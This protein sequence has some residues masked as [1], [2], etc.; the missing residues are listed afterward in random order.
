MSKK[1]QVLQFY[2]SLRFKKYLFIIP[3][4]L[5][6]LAGSVVF[7][8]TFV[9][10]QVAGTGLEVSPPSQEVTVDPGGTTTIKA[11][12]TNKSNET[13]PIA[14]RIED[15][16]AKGDEGQIELT[17]NSEYSVVSWTNLSTTNFTLSPG[18]AREVTATITAPSDAAG[19][20][21]GS[22]VFAVKP[23][24]PEPG[25]A[26]ISQQIASL[27]LVKVAGPV[28]EKIELKSFSAP[29][30]SEFGP[31]TF[32]LAFTNTGNIHT[33]PYGLINVTD[34]FGRKVADIVVPGN[35]IFPQADRVI[36]AQLDQQFLIGPYKATALMYYGAENENL[37]AQT[38]FFV[39]P[40]RI[41]GVI[42]A[43]LVVLFLL[44]KRLKKAGKALFG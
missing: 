43:V 42:L 44:R 32:D 37:T 15:F 17:A 9:T 31:I 21:F 16:T 10:A 30:F 3:I 35:N 2:K 34:V 1:Q 27:F 40:V 26:A 29:V 5:V 33:K 23:E 22:F 18:E 11:K 13:L 6:V 38:T 8:R 14:V 39:F 7:S 12:L 41:A 36:K 24:T 19:G 28:D 4:L 20:R 25:S